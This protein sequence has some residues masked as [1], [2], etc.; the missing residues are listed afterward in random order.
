M[1]QHT[2]TENL[3]KSASTISTDL[4]TKGTSSEYLGPP[5]S[6]LIRTQSLRGSIRPL[7]A[8][9]HADK[10]VKFNQIHKT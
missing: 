4:S 5:H 7:G 6:K 1:Q 9:N 2:G 10:E 3:M 8:S